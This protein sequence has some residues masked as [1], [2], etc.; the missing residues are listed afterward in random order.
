MAV[1]SKDYYE[2]LGVPRGATEESIRK[3]YRELAR[4]HHPDVNKGD[5]A[6]EERFKEI[7]EAY[8]VLSD[9][10][11]RKKYDAY[12]SDW[13]TGADY[14]PP[15]GWETGGRAGFRDYS[16][17]FGSGADQGGGFSD[18]F[19]S[20]FGRR[21]GGRAGSA[22]R[23]RG[24]NVEAEIRISL[25]EAHRGAKRTVSLQVNEPCSNCGGTGIKDGKT[26]PV[27]RGSGVI[28]QKKTLEVTIPAGVRNG[29]VIRL[30]GQGEPGMRGEPAGDLLLHVNIEPHPIFRITEDDDL[31][32][33]LPV[34]PWEAGL[35]S[36]VPVPTLDGSVEMTIRAGAQT[37]Q[38]LRLRGQG[39]NKRGG[40][41][42][43]DLYV[44]IKIVNPPRLNSKEK[45]LYEKLATESRFD[46]R[47][48]L[49]RV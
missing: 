18:F 1:K 9:P 12:G 35:G 27:C 44:I 25:E 17:I 36:K 21:G 19:E 49:P 10:E 20:V 26:C 13:K 23:S 40:A 15:P 24:Q 42:R 16:D 33:D 3:E 31:E 14:T 7:N 47:Q 37:G 48:L 46:A 39:L 29:S 28:P 30:A 45:E 34:A 2:V 22:Y 8:Q 41:G 6:A 5:K 11:K 32:L 4:K 43:T 38:R